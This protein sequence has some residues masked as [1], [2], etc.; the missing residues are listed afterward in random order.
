MKRRRAWESVD[1][2][3]STTQI[4]RDLN[5]G[6][7]EVSRRRRMDAPTTI[8]QLPDRGTRIMDWRKVDFNMSTSELSR[9][10][11]VTPQA[12]SV[13]RRRHAAHTL[14]KMRPKSGI[15]WAAVDFRGRR[16]VELVRELGVSHPTVSRWRKAMAPETVRGYG[17][18]QSGQG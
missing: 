10:Y 6:I 15:D 2:S 11:G 4:A 5:C 1:W 17:R 14:V 18:G 8:G 16:N 12:V 7:T 13:A 3:K 9:L